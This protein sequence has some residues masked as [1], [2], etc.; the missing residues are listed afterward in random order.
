MSSSKPTSSD[1]FTASRIASASGAHSRARCSQ[2]AVCIEGASPLVE[3]PPAQCVISFAPPDADTKGLTVRPRSVA[4]S[5]PA[6]PLRR[7]RPAGPLGDAYLTVQDED[8]QHNMRPA[9]W[10]YGRWSSHRA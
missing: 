3:V 1:A 9:I 2:I 4:R 6:S 10:T 8:H 5:G 7:G